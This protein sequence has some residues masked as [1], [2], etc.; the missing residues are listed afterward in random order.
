MNSFFAYLLLYFIPS[1]GK[2]LFVLGIIAVIFSFICLIGL[3]K[4]DKLI[5]DEKEKEF[6]KE[7]REVYVI[8]LIWIAVIFVGAITPSHKQMVD[9]LHLGSCY[10]RI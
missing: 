3:R 6:R 4:D 1:F 5:D 8:M 7:F 2:F 9:I 10:E